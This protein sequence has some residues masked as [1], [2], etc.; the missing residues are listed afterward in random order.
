MWVRGSMGA[1]ASLAKLRIPRNIHAA[2]AHSPSITVGPSCPSR[3]PTSA[4][5]ASQRM[6]CSLPCPLSPT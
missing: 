1:C 3:C 5:I 4:C 2:G 6:H